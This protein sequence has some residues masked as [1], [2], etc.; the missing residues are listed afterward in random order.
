MFHT[1][2]F[3][4]VSALRYILR[5]DAT[6]KQ[7]IL[8][9][10]PELPEKDG[11][12][13][14]NMWKSISVKSYL[15]S[16]AS[17]QCKVIEIRRFKKNQASQHEYLVAVLQCQSGEERYV[18]I[19]RN[20][21][22]V[23]KSGR[24]TLSQAQPLLDSN[25]AM[26]TPESETIPMGELTGDWTLSNPPL[27]GYPLENPKEPAKP[28]RVG[29]ASA[30]ISKIGQAQDIVSYWEPPNLFSKSDLQL[31]EF[32]L[33]TPI[34]LVH[35]AILAQVVHEKETLYNLFKH[36]CYWYADMIARVIHKRDQNETPLNY[37]S[38]PKAHCYDPRS[39]KFNMI[40]IHTVRPKVV[41][42]IENVY[43]AECKSLE[44][45]VFNRLFN[46]LRIFA[47]LLTF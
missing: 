3:H 1:I 9:C 28:N 35:L 17:R 42:A 31:E 43:L 46:E 25:S 10:F 40:T 33:N 15:E 26:T 5:M 45:S 36:Q 41:E 11:F 12:I 7:P 16:A 24:P 8:D 22:S 6:P 13:S 21:Q 20:V 27:E 19:E 47:D 32:K 4:L 39:G 2:T 38:D 37:N 14:V 34:P 30:S 18:R 44:E 23:D 29:F